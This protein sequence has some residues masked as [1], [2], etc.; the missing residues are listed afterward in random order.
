[1][2]R[3]VMALLHCDGEDSAWCGCPEW[4]EDYWGRGASSV[5]GVPVTSTG[6][7]PGWVTTS[8]GDFCP[9]HAGGAS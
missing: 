8:A 1:M 6:R 3:T 4:S 2:S 9:T 7:A 5:G